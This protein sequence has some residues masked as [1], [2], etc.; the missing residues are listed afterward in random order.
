M[1]RM[2]LENWKPEPHPAGL[3]AD[4]K[5][6]RFHLT[7]EVFRTYEEY[8]AKAL[9]YR[10]R[11]W[12]TK[13][14]NKLKGGLSLTFAEAK[15]IEAKAK[16]KI[17][18]FP[19]SH[20][21]VALRGI[22]HDTGRFQDIAQKLYTFFR[23]NY[24]VGEFVQEKKSGKGAQ[25]KAPVLQIIELLED[26]TIVVRNVETNETQNLGKDKIYR[27]GTPITKDSLEEFLKE[28][29]TRDTYVGAP[30]VVKEKLAKQ[31]ELP[32]QLPPELQVVKDAKLNKKRKSAAGGG[33][34][35]RIKIKYPIE[36]LELSR[37]ARKDEGS[38]PAPST[39]FLLIPELVADSIQLWD[40]FNTFGVLLNLSPFSLFDFQT[41]LINK[42]G[43]SVLLQHCFVASLNLMIQ[44][45]NLAAE[46]DDTIQKEKLSEIHN[47]ETKL[48]KWLNSELK[49]MEEEEIDIPKEL[50]SCANR[51]LS[52][53]SPLERMSFL[54]FLSDK[55]LAST[56]FRSTLDTNMEMISGWK[57][58][59][60]ETKSAHHKRKREI[61]KQS[62]QTE[63]SSD[64]S[65]SEESEDE[66]ESEEEDDDDEFSIPPPSEEDLN[67]REGRR[68]LLEY[69]KLKREH[70]ESV[71]KRKAQQ[72]KEEAKARSAEA[73]QKRAAQ[74]R[75]DAELG[76]FIKKEHKLSNDI[77]T[78][79][80]IKSVPLGSD[81]HYHKYWLFWH[82]PGYIFVENV[83]KSWGYYC[84]MLEVNELRS[85]L[86]DKG[87][88]E[89]AL[90]HGLRTSEAYF[91]PAMKKRESENR[92]NGSSR[93]Q[94]TNKYENKRY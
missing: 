4:D 91:S 84:T 41:A 78:N 22:H 54:R 75:L 44:E 30:H 48:R 45:G 38:K 59:L 8:T 39:D 29:T 37:S 28:S 16:S 52:S 79:S 27:R 47:F 80:L 43:R 14:A 71:R 88:R 34:E 68:L 82:S 62:K 17:V 51:S 50:S 19:D 83:D 74:K 5:V 73:S 24:V 13:Y 42:D 94:N 77:L 26:D 67:G 21:L 89:K 87:V 92:R 33:S 49:M 70:E 63:S 11:N 20:K 23:L 31:Y 61:L 7:G 65:S 25:Q 40:F 9:Q 12:T 93:R 1:K 15:I 60:R 72:E 81:R 32:L 58:E 69:Q 90:L 10:T 66:S 53:T 6:F 35:K 18:K 85:Y 64:E 36:D 76:V 57:K 56:L 46:K 55:I 86:N 3:Q 2:R